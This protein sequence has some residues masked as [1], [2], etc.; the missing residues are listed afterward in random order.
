MP[1][2]SSIKATPQDWEKRAEAAEELLCR[3]FMDPPEGLSIEIGMEIL[4]VMRYRSGKSDLQ[5]LQE[6]V[7][8]VRLSDERADQQTDA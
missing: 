6:F 8:A 2:D 4:D 1:A 5:W 7:D 3:I